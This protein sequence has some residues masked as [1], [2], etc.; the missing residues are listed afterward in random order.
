[1]GRPRARCADHRDGGR[2]TRHRRPRHLGGDGADLQDR[3]DHAARVQRRAEAARAAGLRQG[4]ARRAG[5]R[6]DRAGQRL[7]QAHLVSGAVRDQR[8]ARRGRLARQ[9]HEAVHLQRQPRELLSRDG[10]DR[11]QEDHAGRRDLLPARARASGLHDRPRARQDG[12]AARQQR[13]TGVPGLLHSGLKCCRQGRRVGG[14]VREF[15]AGLERLCRCL[16]ARR[17][18]RALPQS[19]RLGEDP[20]AGRQA[21]HR[22][23]RHPR[24]ARRRCT[25]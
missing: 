11:P 5:D 10:A 25:C 12:R 1:M 24:A 14:G 20:R 8:R 21:N 16:G 9:R 17:G 4:P 18:G 2:G 19:R 23:R 7:G 13:R 3:A 6:H 22:A 15:F